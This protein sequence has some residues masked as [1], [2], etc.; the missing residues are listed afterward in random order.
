MLDPRP[1]LPRLKGVTCR[2]SCFF[3][4]VDL[5]PFTIILP[6]SCPPPQYGGRT[7]LFIGVSSPL[8]WAATRPEPPTILTGDED[9]DVPDSPSQLTRPNSRPLSSKEKGP[10]STVGGGPADQGATTPGACVPL[11]IDPYVAAA[12]AG[13]LTDRDAPRRAPCFAARAV[14]EVEQL[15]L[16]AARKGRLRTLVVCPG[17]MYGCGEDDQ[18]LHMLFRAAWEVR[19]P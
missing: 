15:V 13:A 8:V 2:H 7:Q 19:G 9:L 1:R 18:G 16:R 10:G 14:H 5:P 3:C 12:A 4:T 17:L 11:E 6:L